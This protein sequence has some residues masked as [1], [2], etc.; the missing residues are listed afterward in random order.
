MYAYA[1][2]LMVFF[3]YRMETAFFRFASQKG[4]LEKTFSTVSVALIFSTLLYVC[5]FVGFS[6]FFADWLQYSDHR[7]YILWFTFIIA[8]D[9]LAA[10]PFAKLRLEN[11]PVKFAVLKT[12]NIVV[13]IIFIFFFFK[14]CPWLIEN[15][16]DWWR[17][18]YIEENRVAY[19][20][21][22]NL[23]GSATILLL[24]L[25]EYFKLKFIFDKELLYKMLR[26]AMPLV[27]VGIAAVTNQL[28][29]IPL[30]KEL[31]PGTLVQNQA[32]MGVY[33]AAVK[34]AILM[35]LFVQAFNYAAEPFF[36]RN[37]KRE[38]SRAIYAQV[39]QAFAMVGSIVFLGI[40]L[41]L[42]LI[43]YF[44]GKDFRS[45]LGVVPI[46]LI[47]FLFLGLF[48]N[49]SIWYKLKDRTIIGAYISVVGAMITIGLNVWLIPI[50][51]YYGAAWAALACYGFMAT[52]GYLTGQ[53][54]YPIPYP[55]VRILGYIL[56]AIGA[57]FVSIGLRSYLDESLLLILAVNTFI[58]FI[59]LGLLY[60]LEK[61]TIRSYLK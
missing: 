35:S 12:L 41:Y 15:G 10:I 51:G 52:A 4:Q 50:I 34:L 28:L 55:I 13:N 5:F 16:G 40:V 49:F 42:D 25:P 2:L 53:K 18:I 27:V 43:Q 57:F 30:L 29:N 31:L 14:I 46:L 7:D 32:A 24:L 58:L 61:K 19:V 56:L 20:F 6:Q 44:L 60:Q 9:T 54:Y 1:A 48:Y 17:N 23:I 47:A 26:Y 45:G 39:G 33:G 37:D 38:D 36:F 21:I 22:S 11:R 3:T 59:Y 8:F